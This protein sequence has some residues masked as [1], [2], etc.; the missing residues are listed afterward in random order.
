MSDAPKKDAKASAKKADPAKESPTPEAAKEASVEAKAEAVAEK[1][2][3]A[4]SDAKAEPS[5]PRL[6]EA[7]ELALAAAGT[8]VDSAQEIQRL[9]G[10]V[11]TFIKRNRRNNMILF[12][13]TILILICASIGVFGA[14]V[15]YK[16]SLN[17]FELMAKTNRDGLLVFAGEINALTATSKQMTET[18]KATM[19]ALANVSANAEEL[20]K[21]MQALQVSQN[22][23]SAKVTL[24]ANTDKTINAIK[25]TVDEVQTAQKTLATRLS[26]MVGQLNAM[27]SSAGAAAA[28]AG[29]ANAPGAAPALKP[30]IPQATVRPPRNTASVPRRTEPPITYP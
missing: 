17:E 21:Q 25:Q 22:A 4:K 9:R 1:V 8:A 26:E 7:I 13:A 11:G 27:K 10:E 14:L 28:S 6:D 15:F 12:Y 19:Q 24:A 20:K 5:K 16:R 23:M 29:G 2:K 30:P 3:A 18:S